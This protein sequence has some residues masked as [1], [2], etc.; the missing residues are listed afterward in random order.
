MVKVGAFTIDSY[1]YAPTS[2]C[3]CNDGWG[4]GIGTTVG[5]DKST[6]YTCEI[7]TS[8]TIAVST[9]PPPST[10]TPALPPSLPPT[11]TIPAPTPLASCHTQWKAVLDSFDI[12]G[13]D[14]DESKLDAGGGYFDGTGLLTQLRGCSAVTRWKFENLTISDTQPYQWHASG[15][16][17]VFQKSCIEHAML[18]AGAPSDS[19]S[20][21]S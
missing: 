13:Y 4:A 19:C 1:S 11:S 7:G 5:L 12:Y 14:W 6:T 10:T 8:L 15:Q 3:T 17:T 18:S 9:A 2:K 16:T 20:G 21:S